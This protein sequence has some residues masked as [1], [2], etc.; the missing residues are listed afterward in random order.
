MLEHACNLIRVYSMFKIKEGEWFPSSQI[1]VSA[2]RQ[3]QSC[4]TGKSR[5]R[6]SL[7]YRVEDIKLKEVCLLPSRHISLDHD[8]QAL[9]P[10]QR[11]VKYPR[12]KIFCQELLQIETRLWMVRILENAASVHFPFPIPLVEDLPNLPLQFRG[13]PRTSRSWN[14]VHRPLS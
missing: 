8:M 4:L 7:R 9:F 13:F 12:Q 1:T 2:L 5:L 11:M 14:Q 3:L 10:P 6:V